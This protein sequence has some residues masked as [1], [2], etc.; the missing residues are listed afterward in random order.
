MM[1]LKK[2]IFFYYFF[3]ITLFVEVDQPS[4]LHIVYIHEHNIL[5]I[6]IMHIRMCVCFLDKS[7]VENL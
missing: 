3:V 7:K 5:H 4:N 6:D 1:C 2:I